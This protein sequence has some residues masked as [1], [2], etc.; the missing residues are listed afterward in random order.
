MAQLTKQNKNKMRQGKTGV[1]SSHAAV[2]TPD[3]ANFVNVYKFSGDGQMY[4]KD[5]T[6]NS[7]LLPVPAGGISKF[8]YFY[9]TVADVAGTI[10]ANNGKALFQFGAPENSAG[11]T[12]VAASGD[13]VFGVGTA[14]K[15]RVNWDL[16]AAEPGAM[17]LFI[18]N[19][20]IVGSIRGSGA[21]TQINS[22]Y[23]ILT[24]ADGDVVSLRSDKCAA[25][26]TLQLA[27]TT[28][29]AQVVASV[30]FEKLN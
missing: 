16:S 26:L 30:M 14:G 20:K 23:S 15:Y 4:Q 21:G 2:P 7:T 27:G 1:F 6:G 29:T 19:N 13:I 11:I 12:T 25:A 5:S 9:Q 10:A 22:G 17:A 8:A 24:I 3:N 28:D 18:G